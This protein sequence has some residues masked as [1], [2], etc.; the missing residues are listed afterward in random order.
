MHSFRPLAGITVFRTERAMQRAYHHHLVSVPWRGLRSFGRSLRQTGARY[1]YTFP[2]PGG[3]YGLSDSAKLKSFTGIHSVSVPWRGL[4]SFGRK[5]VVG[6]IYGVSCFRPLAGITVFRTTG[7]DVGEQ[8]P[9]GSFRPLAG[10]TVFRTRL[11]PT[12][13]R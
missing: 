2:S 8:S 5:T 10:I 3:D 9:I 6:L 12:Q 7:H 13:R 11:Y 1:M 4:R